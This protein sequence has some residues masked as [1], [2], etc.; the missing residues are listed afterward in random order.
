MLYSFSKYM[1]YNIYYTIYNIYISIYKFL[2]MLYILLC[3]SSIFLLWRVVWSRPLPTV[4]SGCSYYKCW[5][6]SI[7]ALVMVFPSLSI[8]GTFICNLFLGFIRSS[9][10]YI[11]LNFCWS[12]FCGFGEM[13]CTPF[14]ES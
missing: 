8:K 10:G 1:L 6:K 12:T 13:I 7:N 11:R 9:L 2:R 5:V 4:C 14:I 3:F